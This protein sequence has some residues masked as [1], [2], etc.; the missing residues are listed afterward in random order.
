MEYQVPP[1]FIE[2]MPSFAEIGVSIGGIGVCFVMYYL[3]EKLF[4]LDH[5]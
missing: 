1:T 3:A 2:Y 5:N 4:N